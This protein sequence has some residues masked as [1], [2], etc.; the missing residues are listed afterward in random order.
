MIRAAFFLFSLLIITGCTSALDEGLPYMEETINGFQVKWRSN[1]SESQRNAARE[2]IEDMVSV[3]GGYFMLGAT[4]EQ[5]TF[6][7]QNEYP[8]VPVTLS[9]YHICIH[10]ISNEQYEL[11]IGEQKKFYSYTDWDNFL[12]YLSDITG[13]RFEM[14]TEA[15]WEYA[16]KGGNRSQGY[17]YPGSSVLE[18]VWSGSEFEGSHTPNELGLYN[19]ADLKSEW[20]ADEYEAYAPGQKFR[21]RKIIGPGKERV[22][23][24][25]NFRCSGQSESYLK[26]TNFVL[27]DK[28][29]HFSTGSHIESDYDMRYC[30][31][32]ARSY[33]YTHISRRD[34]GCRPVINISSCQQ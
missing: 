29:G 5:E 30:R 10:E 14:P 33:A 24:G 2:I 23:R 32:T 26:P 15:Q 17:V 27:A 11:I 13:L 34:I 3:D 20:C 19:M 18:E 8:L 22:V 16:A 9:D 21:D 12:T 1:A 4:P 28:F 6:A 7:R 31:I 25:G